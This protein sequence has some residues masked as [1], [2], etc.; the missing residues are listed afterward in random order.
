M[1]A[2]VIS[3]RKAPLNPPT[4][5][6]GYRFPLPLWERVRVRASA[7]VPLLTLVLLACFSCA[8]PTTDPTATAQSEPHV[9]EAAPPPVAANGAPRIVFSEPVYDFGKAEQGDQV[10]PPV[11]K[12][13]AVGFGC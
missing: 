9:E 3:P 13:Q 6:S 4:P 8:A 5:C 7:A 2:G 12:Q 10:V 1:R 11:L